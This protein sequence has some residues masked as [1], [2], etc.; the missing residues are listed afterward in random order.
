MFD[1]NGSQLEINV[2][3]KRVNL[4]VE[5]AVNELWRGELWSFP[6]GYYFRFLIHRSG[7]EILT[8]LTSIRIRILYF[9]AIS[10]KN[11]ENVKPRCLHRRNC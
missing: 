3:G 2:E 6:S 7:T 8:S 1:S 9:R 11:V 5:L 10:N 4:L